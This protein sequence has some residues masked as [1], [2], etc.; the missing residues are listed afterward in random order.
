MELIIDL[1]DHTGKSHR[2]GKLK[3]GNEATVEQLQDQIQST[4]QVPV[5]Y[6]E[7]FCGEERIDLLDSNP[8]LSQLNLKRVDALIVK[9]ALLTNWSAYL[10][11]VERIRRLTT[12][13]ATSQRKGIAIRGRQQLS[14]LDDSDFFVAYPTLH[15]QRRVIDA[16]INYLVHNSMNGHE[17]KLVDKPK[18]LGGVQL[19][20]FVFAKESSSGLTNKYYAK[21]IGILPKPEFAPYFKDPIDLLELFV[22]YLL[23]LIGVDADE[24]HI[25]SDTTNGDVYLATKLTC[26]PK[27]IMTA[28]SRKQLDLLQGLR[29]LNDLFVNSGNYGMVERGDDGA[30]GLVQELKIVDFK[31]NL[32]QKPKISKS[33]QNTFHFESYICKWKLS[34][35]VENAKRAVLDDVA[36]KDN[37]NVDKEVLEF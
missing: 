27:L 15:T 26:V 9:H 14:P 24:V 28:E 18:N 1:Q 8:L 6:Q 37:A 33:R 30:K 36:I 31:V 7:I 23:S 10:K 22:Y 11:Q 25:V 4:F 19:G 3:F 2:K 32:K 13:R 35:N 5:D 16:E 21:T 29:C 20:L 34:D 17:V 12:S